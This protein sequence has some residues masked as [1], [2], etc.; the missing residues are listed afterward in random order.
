MSG[1]R[2]VYNTAPG[3]TTTAPDAAPQASNPIE[4]PPTFVPTYN[5]NYAPQQTVQ[6]G[7]AYVGTG[8]AAPPQPSIAASTQLINGAQLTPSVAT[9]GPAINPAYQCPKTFMRLTTGCIPQT[10]DLWSK[11]T[12]PV[13]AVL[14]PMAED[15]DFQVC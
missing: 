7:P 3:I 8:A 12:L 6:S 1:K 14:H 15:P 11:C 4:Q 5:T 13:G 2:R 9:Y 10:S